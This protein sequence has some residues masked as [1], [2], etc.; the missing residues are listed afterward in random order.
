M[1]Y[2]AH[3]R[4]YTR[5]MSTLHQAMPH[6]FSGRSNSRSPHASDLWVWLKMNWYR[7]L[8][9]RLLGS[10]QK[11][12]APFPLGTALPGTE[13]QLPPPRA[14]DFACLHV[15]AVAVGARHLPRAEG[16][17]ATARLEKGGFARA[18]ARGGKEKF[19]WVLIGEKAREHLRLAPTQ[20]KNIS[21]AAPASLQIATSLMSL[22]HDSFLT[23]L[24]ASA[25]WS[26]NYLP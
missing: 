14:E 12:L 20:W 8:S 18:C 25:S 9:H 24:D 5:T 17:R 4:R 13:S 6:S 7:L 15:L 16:G 2:G 1:E 22:P 11:Q 21:V 26:I 3:T 10:Q 19:R 23:I